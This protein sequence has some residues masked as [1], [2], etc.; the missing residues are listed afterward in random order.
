MEN[1][2]LAV[3]LSLL[4][5]AILSFN[6]DLRIPISLVNQ[7]ME[8]AQTRNAIQQNKF[9]FRKTSNEYETCEMTMDE[10]INGSVRKK[11]SFQKFQLKL[12]S[13]E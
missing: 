1:A 12:F 2:A 7:N 5:R 6:I 9:H 10:I 3:F 8:R 13:L 4:T 11:R